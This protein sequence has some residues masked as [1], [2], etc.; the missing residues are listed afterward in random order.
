MYYAKQL[1][2][3][4]DRVSI[5]E[6]GCDEGCMCLHFSVAAFSVDIS[7]HKSSGGRMFADFRG[8]TIRVHSRNMGVGLDDLQLVARRIVATVHEAAEYTA[9]LLRYCSWKQDDNNECV[10]C[11]SPRAV[12][13]D[14]LC[15]KHLAQPIADTYDYSR[16][17]F[18]MPEPR[19]YEAPELSEEDKLRESAMFRAMERMIMEN[20]PEWV[21]TK[22]GLT[23]H[24]L[25]VM[26]GP[27]LERLTELA[28]EEYKKLK[29]VTVQ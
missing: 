7:C 4:L 23:I 27:Y 24:S 9:L 29:A 5:F 26:D 16:I 6:L 22:L 20:P 28:E 11:G 25:T 15:P 17:H 10:Y 18:V 12:L 1:L 3:I 8:I 19:E 14:Y 13:T 21:K 2:S